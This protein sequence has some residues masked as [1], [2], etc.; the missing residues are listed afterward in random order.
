M[1]CALGR[2][3]LLHNSCRSA[4]VPPRRTRGT[5]SQRP[6]S[7]A[8]KLPV[9]PRRA[10]LY[11]GPGPDH[12]RRGC[13]PAYRT[14]TPC[15]SMKPYLSR[16]LWLIFVVIACTCLGA[17]MMALAQNP[18][19]PATGPLATRWT[20][21]VTPE[22]VH[23]EH[24][25]P[26][27]V[28]KAGTW[29]NLNGL[30]QF[31]LGTPGDAAPIGKRLADRILVPFPIESALSG[32]MR[33]TERAWYRRTLKLSAAW[34]SGRVLL[35]FG[36]VEW[37]ATVWFN[38]HEVGVHRG[39]YDGFSYDVTD[40]LA[41]GEAQEIVVGVFD[42]S[43]SGTQPRGKQVN[44]PKGIYYTPST[45]IW[46][47]VWLESVPKHYIRSLS[48]VPSVT[49][50]SVAI[51]AFPSDWE[52]GLSIEA[53]ASGGGRKFSEIRRDD[54]DED[55]MRLA[56]SIPN[57]RLWTPED[58]FLYDLEVRL[59][60]AA[61]R[62]QDT[63]RSYFGMRSVDVAPDEA[64][65]PR[66]RVNGKFVFQVGPLD[67]GFWPDG[68]YTPPTDEALRY[69]LEVTKK[70]GFNMVRKHVKVEPERW[71]YWCDKLGL[72]VWQ[73]MPS[74]DADVPRGG[75]EI[76][77]SPPSARQFELELAR[78]IDGRGTH[79]SI[80]MWVVFNEGWGQYDTARVTAS[81]MR[82][83]PSRLVS[84]A[85]GWNDMPAGHVIDVHSYPGPAAPEHDGRR[86][87]VLGEFGGLGLG[88]D[89]HTWTNT[90]WGY[91]GTASSAELTWRYID[92]MRGAYEL[93]EKTGLSAAVYT[94]TTDVETEANGLLT[95]DREV[96]KVDAAQ[97]AAANRG[98]FPAVTSLVET[99]RE[100]P[101][102]WRYTT[103]EPPE[104]WQETEFEDADWTE[105]PGGFGTPATPG[106]VVRT[107]WDTT[108]IWLRREISL[109]AIPAGELLLTIHH[110]EAAEVYIN[111]VRV[112]Q[113]QEYTT[114]YEPVPLAPAARAALRKGKNVIA[115]HCKQ[116]G[117][118][119]YIDLGLVVAA[120]DQA[121]AGRPQRSRE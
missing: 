95:Y 7:A 2:P 70:L 22:N 37:E 21:L 118:G 96:L 119:Q 97:I 8:T 42:P 77:R 26:Q 109:E 27:M 89:G 112:A 32:Q 76:T 105:G 45:G 114:R 108:D 19:K 72:L 41:E 106:T 25:R 13:P 56:L 36:A 34:R 87:I 15:T 54:A 85:S 31:A 3:H 18:W 99:S 39:G 67:Q 101:Q 73:D 10:V 14:H 80:I 115:V 78:L 23:S 20:N 40:A 117:G 5:Y 49:D 17:P 69:D 103:K 75:G 59:V 66:I 90:T 6:A 44:N 63:V 12:G 16:R 83:D 43:S 51:S 92:L 74:G 11:S 55:P 30:W 94:Q 28:R 111:G 110:D 86:A 48:I 38:G 57:P 104:G 33:S 60:D 100:Q 64:G 91:R 84:C 35:H 93:A 107:T 82:Q 50:S 52:V 61:G 113:V 62:V 4:V 71:Y 46:Q 65:R 58:P 116:T 29:L 81:A 68:L 88:V 1:E 9:E 79:P 24:P 98:R 120:T 102:A 121:Q 53:T 47:S